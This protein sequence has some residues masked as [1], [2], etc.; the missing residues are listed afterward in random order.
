MALFFKKLLISPLSVILLFVSYFLSIF[1][2]RR[3]I[4]SAHF[5]YKFFGHS[6]IEPAIASSF[7]ASN[8]I[9][10]FSSHARYSRGDNLFLFNI[11]RALFSDSIIP[12]Y[13][14][15]YI[16]NHSFPLLRR[17]ISNYYSP[18]FPKRVDRE[19]YYLSYLS[20]DLD[21]PWRSLAREKLNNPVSLREDASDLPILFACRTSHFHSSSS[22]VS[23]QD[24]RNLDTSELVYFLRSVLQHDQTLSFIFYSSNS[25]ITHI[26]S[27]LSEYHHRI[28]YVDEAINDVI[29]L[30]TRSRLLVNNGNGIG[31]FA[32]SLGFPTLYL[33]HSPYQSWHSSHLN[34]VAI[35]PIYSSSSTISCDPFNSLEI[36][37]SV[38][39]ILPYDFDISY[40]SKGI[41]LLPLTNYPSSVFSDSILQAC[42]LNSHFLLYR[43]SDLFLQ[44]F[45]NTSSNLL[46]WETFCRLAP[47]RVRLWHRKHFLA[48][49]LSF[50]E[51]CSFN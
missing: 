44:K 2:F 42:K 32:Y 21:F 41:S 40:S 17:L 50:L 24:Y 3:K 46:F 43:H 31:A 12:L 36:A 4:Y 13:Y 33:K 30:L 7:I 8:N 38:S 9:K 35:P 10:F 37:F 16:Y 51:H 20:T 19:I 15:H 11:S 27:L 23:S 1:I 45:V 34:A 47:E 49:S 29:P 6:A 5:S 22:H 39:S 25:T 18:L 14:F 28:E 26:R 48:I